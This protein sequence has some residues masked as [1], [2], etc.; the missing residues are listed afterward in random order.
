M[1]KYVDGWSCL[2]LLL[3]REGRVCLVLKAAKQWPLEKTLVNVF[4]MIQRFVLFQ[5]HQQSTYIYRR[6]SLLNTT[7][8]AACREAIVYIHKRLR[9]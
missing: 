3:K 6:V 7:R 1:E 8:M 4:K 9:L 2:S 5:R